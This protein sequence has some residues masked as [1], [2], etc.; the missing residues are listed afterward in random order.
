VTT[1]A[2][3]FGGEHEGELVGDGIEGALHL[4]PPLSQRLELRTEIRVLDQRLE[5]RAAELG[6]LRVDVREQLLRGR[7]AHA[8]QL[9]TSSVHLG[10]RQHLRT[11]PRA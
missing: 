7:V 9:D 5:I 1:S 4:L 2:R 10:R 3:P 8:K 6:T 11:S